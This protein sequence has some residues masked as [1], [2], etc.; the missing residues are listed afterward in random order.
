MGVP[1]NSAHHSSGSEK[2]TNDSGMQSTSGPS[3]IFFESLREL[4]VKIGT[5]VE[6]LR[7][8]FE[9]TKWKELPRRRRAEL[10]D[11]IATVRAVP[12]RPLT[13]FVHHCTS[14]QVIQPSL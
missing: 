12:R 5:L 3:S 6:I 1:L 14:S 10:Q 2:R 9:K 11:P 4:L 8:E 13:Q 7:G